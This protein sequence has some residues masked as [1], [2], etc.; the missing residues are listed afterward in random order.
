M[1]IQRGAVAGPESGR[2]LPR[3][4][5]L[6]KIPFLTGEVVLYGLSGRHDFRKS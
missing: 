1:D 2:V 5:D 4:L 3:L 6:H